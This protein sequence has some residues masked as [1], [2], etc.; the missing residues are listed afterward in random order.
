MNE[1][2]RLW[3]LPRPQDI[4]FDIDDYLN[5]FVFRSQLYRLPK[6]VSRFLGYREKPTSDVGN[7]LIAI[8]AFVG[9][10]CGILLVGVVFNYSDRIKYYHAPVVF[11]SLV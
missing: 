8:W 7:I 6:P 1:G 2:R 11:A 4:H 5:R 3:K 9:T 10:F